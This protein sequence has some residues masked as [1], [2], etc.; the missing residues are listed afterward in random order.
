MRAKAVLTCRCAVANEQGAN[1]EAAAEAQAAEAAAAAALTPR[2]A[3][4]LLFAGPLWYAL[5]CALSTPLFLMLP[6]W[7]VPT[8]PEAEADAAEA[9]GKDKSDAGD[10][11][12]PEKAPEQPGGSEDAALAV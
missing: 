6:A 8:E 2:E 12:A 10:D 3:R 4:L 1:G 11:S 9:H 5:P 7:V